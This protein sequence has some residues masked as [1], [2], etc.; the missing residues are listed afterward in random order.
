M[1][2]TAIILAGGKSSRM[3]TD[4]ALLKLGDKNML[5]T[6]IKNCKPVCNSIIISSNHINHSSFGYPVVQ[7]EISNCGPIGGIYTCLK[8]SATDWNFIISV[9]TPFVTGEFIRFIAGEAENCDVA[10]PVHSGSQEPLIAVYSKKILPVIEHQ[11]ERRQFRIHELIK[12][13][14]C[15]LINTDSWVKNMPLLF[16][17]LNRPEDFH[18]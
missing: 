16:K 2:L 1:K 7:D 17:N 14:K 11:I 10:V 9:D 12:L 3:G 6:V 8:Q 13:A 18:F 5:E 15:K 4:K